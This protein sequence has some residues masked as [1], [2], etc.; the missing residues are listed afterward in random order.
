MEV[1]AIA[2]AEAKAV[3]EE[4]AAGA[5]LTRAPGRPRWAAAAQPQGA[6]G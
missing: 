6:D 1:T 2:A 4:R 3:A 5:L